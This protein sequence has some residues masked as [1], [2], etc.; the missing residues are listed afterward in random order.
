MQVFNPMSGAGWSSD[1]PVEQKGFPNGGEELLTEKGSVTPQD[2][3]R[4][5]SLHEKQTLAP[6][7][8]CITARE[9]ALS[10]RLRRGALQNPVLTEYGGH[11]YQSTSY[12]AA[13]L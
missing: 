5:L 11:M 13:L 4:S 12:K 1:D 3:L 2:A 6:D 9:G 10:C 7:T 8:I